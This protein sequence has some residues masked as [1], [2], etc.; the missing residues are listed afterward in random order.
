MGGWVSRLA[1]V[2]RYKLRGR[3]AARSRR[4]QAQAQTANG[5][6]GRGFEGPSAR[7]RGR[8]GGPKGGSLEALLSYAHGPDAGSLGVGNRSKGRERRDCAT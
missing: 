8:E 7:V 2:P 5:H 1:Q 4:A 6:W 3:E